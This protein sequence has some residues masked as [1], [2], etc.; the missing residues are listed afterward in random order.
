MVVLGSDS[1]YFGFQEAI[2]TMK[3]NEVAVFIIS[4]KLLW[5]PDGYYDVA[6][7]MAPNTDA[8]YNIKLLDFAEIG[9][10]TAIDKMTP[11][12]KM[13]FCVLSVEAQKVMDN[14]K[15]NFKLGYTN[16]A[17]R[18]FHDIITSLELS[19][20]ANDDEVSAQTDLL[21]QIYRNLTVCY[22]RVSK[23]QKV[24]EMVKAMNKLKSTSKD[25]KSLF[26]EGRALM[27]LGEY[28]KAKQVLQTAFKLNPDKLIAKELS[29]LEK[30]NKEYKNNI[31]N[32][33]QKAL[34]NKENIERV[35]EVSEEPKKKCYDEFEI[36]IFK[37]IEVFK[38][39]NDT[40]RKL[41]DLQLT[42]DNIHSIEDLVA[43]MTDIGF[44]ESH[45]P[46]TFEFFR[47]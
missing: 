47:K 32:I 14:A 13:Q 42:I 38:R 44:R 36:F 9:D 22:N 34:Q 7:P 12:E 17:I 46:L 28:D 10:S 25:S 2:R 41:P 26:Q 3:K 20:T 43:D 40:V 35:V 4:C 27:N 45:V 5:G 18:L 19:T 29:T 16:R 1:H 30:K 39:S 31:G 33:W 24:C 8:L 37:F 21:Y 6:K 23:P 11:E 15:D